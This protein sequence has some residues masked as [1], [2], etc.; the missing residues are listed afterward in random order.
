M[1]SRSSS[2][3]RDQLKGEGD[4]YFS[5][6]INFTRHR[7]PHGRALYGEGASENF[8]LNTLLIYTYLRNLVISVI[9][10]GIGIDEK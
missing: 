7:Q 1:N 3:C 5:T 8:F 10:L 6:F 2:S 9:I 4:K